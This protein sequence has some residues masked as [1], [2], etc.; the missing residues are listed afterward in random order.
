MTVCL[1]LPLIL[2]R[3]EIYFIKCFLKG[4]KLRV[5]KVTYHNQEYT[6]ERHRSKSSL[7]LNRTRFES[8]FI[9]LKV[10]ALSTLPCPAPPHSHL[11]LVVLRDR[12]SSSLIEHWPM[13]SFEQLLS[14]FYFMRCSQHFGGRDWQKLKE[15]KSIFQDSI[16]QKGGTEI[17]GQALQLTRTLS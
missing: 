3:P 13:P 12:G 7:G 6:F 5:I 11:P 9:W 17:T 15:C 8:H 1:I 4:R 14:M 10:C 2:I 16:A